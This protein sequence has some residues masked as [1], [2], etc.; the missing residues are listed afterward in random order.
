MFSLIGTSFFIFL[1]ILKVSYII[2]DWPPSLVS[3]VFVLAIRFHADLKEGESLFEGMN[4][5]FNNFTLKG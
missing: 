2:A 4:D 1:H 5:N 3:F